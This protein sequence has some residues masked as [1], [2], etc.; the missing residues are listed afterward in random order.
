MSNQILQNY[1]FE[2]EQIKNANSFACSD[3]ATVNVPD[4]NLFNYSTG[5]VNFNNTS[6]QGNDTKRTL[7]MTQSVITIPFGCVLNVSPATGKTASFGTY[8]ANSYSHDVQ[9]VFAVAPKAYHH[10]LNQVS[11]KFGGKVINQSNEYF[12]YYLN[13]KLKAMNT[14]QYEILGDMLDLSMDSSDSYKY[15]ADLLEVN[16]STVPT[17]D[18]SLGNNPN[19]YVN[20]GHIE[21]MRKLNVDWLSAS[22]NLA[23]T[24]IFNNTVVQDTY[25]TGLIAVCDKNGAKVD[26]TAGSAQP[27]SYLVFQYV[28]TIPLMFV[29]EFYEKLQSIVTLSQFELRLQ[30]NLASNNSWVINCG[31]KGADNALALPISS[32]VSNA[33]VGQTCPFLV[34]SPTS[35]GG[36]SGLTIYTSDKDALPK[37]TLKPFIGY[38]GNSVNNLSILPSTGLPTGQPAMYP[39]QMWIPSIAYNADY[40][41]TIVNMPPQKLLYNDFIVDTTHTDITGGT[42]VQKMLTYQTGRLRKLYILPYLSA[43]G[44]ATA[45]DPRQ[46]LISSAPNTCSLCRIVNLNVQ[47]GSV[48]VFSQPISFQFNHYYNSS[49]ISQGIANG[50]AFKSYAMSGRVKY[51]DFNSCYGAYVV[52]LERVT[53]EISDETIKNIQLTFKIN[54]QNTVKYNM[55]YIIEYQSECYVDRLT[56]Q[57]VNSADASN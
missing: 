42:Q 6:L 53:D 27:I 20:K 15:D 17:A 22:S 32:I 54:T 36:K 38:Y 26:V 16:N 24:K 51:S 41:Q 7:E 45:C 52:D 50:N 5:W 57:V 43:T 13:E 19:T 9:N 46:S 28:A 56:G 3:V 12:N 10:I 25:A 49:L 37:I 4:S 35:N 34:S 47:L 33:S 14:D 21:R 18:L 23:D 39:C 2:T 11:N 29:S 44:I 31:A 48:N 30:T 1:L 55:L 8:A 40:Q